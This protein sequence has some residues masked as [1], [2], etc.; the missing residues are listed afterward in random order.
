MNLDNILV[1]ITNHNNNENAIHLKN[2][3]SNYFETIIIDSESDNVLDEFDVKLNNV[4]YTGLF[5]ESFNQTKIRNKE[6]CFFIASDVYIND[7]E[8]LAHCVESLDEDVYVYAPSSR[9][10]SHA[11]CKNFSSYSLREVPYLEGFCFLS[12]IKVVDDLYPVSLEKNK[13]GFG[14]DLLM[15][16]NCIKRLRKICVVDDRI[17]IYHREGTGYDMGAALR[18]MYNWMFNDFDDIVKEYTILYS[19]SPGY[20]KLLN[21]LKL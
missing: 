17:E 7:F 2:N 21:Y 3:L 5:N 10:Q 20:E 4:Y 19:K 18:D 16:L 15:G 12:N 13:Y 14:I 8:K 9:G 11:H 6:Y 1:C